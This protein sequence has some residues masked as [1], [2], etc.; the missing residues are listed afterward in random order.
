[1]DNV[2]F[3]LVE[4]LWSVEGLHRRWNARLVGECMRLIFRLFEARKAVGMMMPVNHAHGIG[5]FR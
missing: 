3:S 2:G 1:M 5:S 4:G